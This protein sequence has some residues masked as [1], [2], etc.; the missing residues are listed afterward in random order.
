M[1]DV[2]QFCHYLFIVPCL[3][4]VLPLMAGAVA[5]AT[6]RQ[7]G[8]LDWQLSL[9]ASRL[10][11]WLVK[12]AVVLALAAL[13]GGVLASVLDAF[14]VASLN[15]KQASY[16]FTGV[17]GLHFF[18]FYGLWSGGYAVLFAA[19]GIYVSTWTRDAY[20]AFVIG[21]GLIAFT[22]AVQAVIDPAGVLWPIHVGPFPAFF[23]HPGVHYVAFAVMAYVVL[24]LGLGNYRFEGFSWRRI[25]VQMLVWTVVVNAVAWFTLRA[26]F[27]LGRVSMPGVYGGGNQLRA[28]V[29]LYV[30]RTALLIGAVGLCLWA[31]VSR[32]DTRSGGTSRRRLTALIVVAAFGMAVWLRLLSLS[33][34]LLL[35][36]IVALFLRAFALRP[37][38]VSAGWLAAQIA[39]WIF[40]V[41]APPWLMLRADSIHKSVFGYGAFSDPYQ[42]PATN[43]LGFFRYEA[44]PRQWP[45]PVGPDGDESPW[46]EFDQPIFRLPGSN[47]IVTAARCRADDA[48]RFRPGENRMDEAPLLRVLEA[49]VVTGAVRQYPTAFASA[50]TAIDPKQPVYT[51][52]MWLIGRFIVPLDSAGLVG[53]A[54]DSAVRWFDGEPA[55]KFDSV[56][57]TAKQASN[58][59]DDPANSF[60]TRW[61]A[62]V[63]D[64]V[65]CTL[66]AADEWTSRGV[67]VHALFRTTQGSAVRV[68]IDSFEE[69]N[70][71]RRAY[72]VSPDC[73]WYTREIQSVRP[74]AIVATDGASSFTIQPKGG[75]IIVAHDKTE[76]EPPFAPVR[77][78]LGTFAR[79]L[80]VSA[81]GRFLAFIRV[82]TLD[83]RVGNKQV[84]R[85]FPRSIEMAVL[86]LQTGEE[87][88]LKEVSPSRTSIGAYGNDLLGEMTGAATGHYWSTLPDRR[89][90]SI[91]VAGC[92][93]NGLVFRQEGLPMVW[94]M[95]GK[96]AVLYDEMLFIYQGIGGDRKPQCNGLPIG[97]ILGATNLH[98]WD[99]H[100]L[101]V[102]GR[103]GIWR[104]DT[105]TFRLDAP[106]TAAGK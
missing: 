35:V 98:F 95:D 23:V 90:A 41:Y 29:L 36:G 66:N 12:S 33:D 47:R 38:S 4:L 16:V 61:G 76:T 83:A 15:A 70:S 72:A 81:D 94:S 45:G 58:P 21:L 64:G 71:R 92:D 51:A 75:T 48:R 1:G 22:Y 26:E 100:T 106:K 6:E 63:V 102:W 68:R 55:P 19:L 62:P 103:R 85:G 9:P 46:L 42:A 69:A 87:T 49:D 24:N 10:T 13:V 82:Q 37:K 97:Q 43:L 86:N 18:T 104:I 40:V 11:Q 52:G 65:G 56:I 27:N 2:V 3:V 30:C 57:R 84:A 89:E 91:T 96:L 14:L 50:I 25:V 28:I 59:G 7:L 60:G 80:A 77:H 17:G 73:K 93:R 101:L 79:N 39:V 8:T 32:A 53:H 74:L 105:P 88:P 31:F 34:A 20:R 44:P 54:L 99:G 78:Q 5:V 67:G